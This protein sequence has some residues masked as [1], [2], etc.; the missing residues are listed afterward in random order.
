VRPKTD[1]DHGSGVFVA[2]ATL[3]VVIGTALMLF[4]R[5]PSAAERRSVVH[6][7]P[8]AASARSM[9]KQV[10]LTV[11]STPRGVLYLDGVK[12]GLTPITN[13]RLAPGTYRLRIEQKGYRPVSETIS[14]K[15]TRPISRRYI[16]R[17]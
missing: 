4:T 16:L 5:S 10:A 14:V 6:S 8:P 3:A 17:R 11:R 13:Y 15:G 2:L 12:I 7:A 1:S 9:K